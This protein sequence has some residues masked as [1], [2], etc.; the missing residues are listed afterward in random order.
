MSN[1]IAP[2]LQQYNTLTIED[3]EFRG[4]TDGKGHQHNVK[5]NIVYTGAVPG[6]RIL[7]PPP[8]FFWGGGGLDP[9][10]LKLSY[11]CIL[12]LVH[13]YIQSHVL[14]AAFLHVDHVGS[15]CRGQLHNPEN[16]VVEVLKG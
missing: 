11:L 14:R 7:E 13:L 16:V 10:G 15:E 8:P 4:N 2:Q 12:L 6:R 3:H 1:L 9:P 5:K